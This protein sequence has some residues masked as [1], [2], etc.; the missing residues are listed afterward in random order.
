MKRK[1]SPLVLLGV[2]AL[3]V[4][5]AVSVSI[6]T[7]VG[8]FVGDGSSLTNMPWAAN[9]TNFNWVKISD[10]APG[11]SPYYTNTFSR[12]PIDTS[13]AWDTALTNAQAAVVS[14]KGRLQGVFFDAGTYYFSNGITMRPGVWFG[15]V[16]IAHDPSAGIGD[17]TNNYTML[18]TRKGVRAKSTH[19]TIQGLSNIE[20][21]G[22]TNPLCHIWY[23]VPAD[24]VGLN[25]MP[26]SAMGDVGLIVEGEE[27]GQATWTGGF[28]IQ[29]VMVSGYKLPVVSDGNCQYWF[30][31]QTSGRFGFLAPGVADVNL[32][33]PF[34]SAVDNYYNMT[35]NLRLL[36]FSWFSD[37][38]LTLIRNSDGTLKRHFYPADQNTFINPMLGNYT[39]G[40]SWFIGSSRGCE[41]IIINDCSGVAQD[42]AWLYGNTA[43]S[44]KG[45][46]C[47]YKGNT[48]AAIRCFGDRAS[49]CGIVLESGRFDFP[50][51][52]GDPYAF[53]NTNWTFI[54]GYQIPVSGKIQNC[55]ISGGT[56]DG[57]KDDGLILYIKDNYDKTKIEVI[58][59]NLWNSVGAYRYAGPLYSQNY[60]QKF[61]VGYGYGQINPPMF[62]LHNM[63]IERDWGRGN[64]ETNLLNQSLLGASTYGRVGQIGLMLGVPDYYAGIIQLNGTNADLKNS[65]QNTNNMHVR[66]ITSDP[67]SGAEVAVAGEIGNNVTVQ[68]LKVNGG[69][70]V[71]S[72]T[73][74]TGSS[75][76]GQLPVTINGVTY[77][78]DLKK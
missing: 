22:T 53:G 69:L 68:A 58:G 55:L 13:F 56:N 8:K 20:I 39:N 12:G 70:T 45:A 54:M 59:G 21:I 35:N 60:L 52:N 50:Q 15:G 27:S 28:Q 30:K 26:E 44:V 46:N 31:L 71:N 40:V 47:E 34:N 10:Y 43:F 62:Q 74:S 5:G 29:N 49:Y 61:P 76:V 48:D 16:G 66:F 38:Y 64:T 65:S 2:I 23:S 25:N 36:G 77:Y 24:D 11:Q 3:V 37:Q 75:V 67:Q 7:Y 33:A 73:N 57:W 9:I 51:T 14:S 17:K 42:Y 72:A 1:I 32:T 18:W 78:L 63:G 4:I 6:N 41:P 19:L